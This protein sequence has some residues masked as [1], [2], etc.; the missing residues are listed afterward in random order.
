MTRLAQQKRHQDVSSEILLFL[1]GT[2]IGKTT[3]EIAHA[4]GVSRP[5]IYKYLRLLE[6][7]QQVEKHIIG[8]Y[9]AY[10]AKKH[11]SGALFEDLYLSLMAAIKDLQ[12]SSPD[13][14]ETLFLHF[15]YYAKDIIKTLDPIQALKLSGMGAFGQ[16]YE[17][18]EQAVTI[19]RATLPRL[20]PMAK[21]KFEIVKPLGDVKPM[22]LLLKL[23]DPG[24]I[25]KNSDLHYFIAAYL[26]EKFLSTYTGIDIYC[27]VAEPILEE[28][29][30]VFFELGF[31]EKPFQDYVVRANNS[32]T[33]SDKDMLDAIRRFYESAIALDVA[34]KVVDGKPHYVFTFKNNRDVE[35]FFDIITRLNLESIIIGKQLIS[36][37]TAI[38]TRAWVPIENWEKEPFSILDCQT[39][40]SY[41]L[42]GLLRTENEAYR[43]GRFCIHFE[44]IDGGWRV[45]MKEKVDFD[46]LFTPMQDIEKRREIYSQVTDNTDRFM[47]LRMQALDRLKKDLAQARVEKLTGLGE[48]EPVNKEM[49]GG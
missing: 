48:N 33:M 9:K 46:M 7:D 41:A 40:L 18:L 32:G 3:S 35:E 5:T 8:S 27:R 14:I 43:F 36:E 45:S 38:L 15:R 42:E 22:A 44:R 11:E 23:E 12:A 13:S 21:G 20:L 10:T 19:T 6:R 24:Y 17:F 34:E 28:S 16:S 26:I 2:D 4:L 39:N 25:K 37:N 30:N 47:A 31:I 29:K 49:P 1:E